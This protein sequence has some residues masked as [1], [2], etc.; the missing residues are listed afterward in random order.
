[1]KNRAVVA[2]GLLVA[3]LL[4]IVGVWAARRA[5]AIIIINSRG[6]DTGMF[7]I[8]AAQT[9]RVHVLNAS[10]FAADDPPCIV[11]VRFFDAAGALLNSRQ[12]KIVPGRAEFVDHTDPTL[13][14][15]ERKHI[16]A[17]VVQALLPEFDQPAPVCIAT[18]EVF[19]NRTGQAG[20]IIVNS[21]PVR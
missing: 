5:D 14:S 20:I 2:K 12:I 11:E 15:G 17:V 4:V 9:A 7:G 21:H 16:R 6:V 13:R 18:A 8:T 1:M 3:A 19:E 10:G